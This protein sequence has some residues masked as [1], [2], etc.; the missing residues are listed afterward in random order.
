MIDRRMRTVA[1]AI[2]LLSACVFVG[3]LVFL[4]ISASIAQR[5]LD[6]EVR[7]EFFR[8]IGGRF[9]LIGGVALFLLV[10]TGIELAV[11]LFPETS[12]L[13]DTNT[14]MRFLAKMGLVALVICLVVIHSAVQSPKIRALR[15]ESLGN[16]H[17]I[18]LA[19]RVKVRQA[20]SGMTSAAMLGAAFAIVVLAATL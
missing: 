11:N 10:L 13:V 19:R 15:L 18:E 6:D 14:G 4:A 12:M 16:P 5:I 20:R 2:H 1:L 8:Q 7:V 9:A 3:G 17:D